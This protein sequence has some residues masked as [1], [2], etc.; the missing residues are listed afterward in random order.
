MNINGDILSTHVEYIQGAI[1]GFLPLI[2]MFAGI[3]LSF[4]II[5]MLRYTILKMVK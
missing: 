2:A 4:A 1:A 5:N 3:F